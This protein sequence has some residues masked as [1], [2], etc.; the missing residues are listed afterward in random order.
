MH[1]QRFLRLAIMNNPPTLRGRMKHPLPHFASSFRAFL[2]VF[3][4][5]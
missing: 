4:R 1:R 3:A 5:P 2:F